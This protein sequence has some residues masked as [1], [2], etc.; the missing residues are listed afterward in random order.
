MNSFQNIF[1]KA[2]AI[3]ILLAVLVKAE[4]QNHHEANAEQA[5]EIAREAD[6]FPHRFHGHH[7]FFGYPHHHGYYGHPRHYGYYGGHHGFHH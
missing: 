6:W 7:G 3:W 5:E 4:P 2:A 1:S